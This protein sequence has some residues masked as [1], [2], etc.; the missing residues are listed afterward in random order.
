VNW[1]NPKYWSRLGRGGRPTYED[2]CNIIFSQV[3]VFTAWVVFINFIQDIIAFEYVTVWAL[4]LVLLAVTMAFYVANERGY[5]LVS[6]IA[7]GI[8]L[9]A[10]IFLLSATTWNINGVGTVYLPIM[11]TTILVMGRE[12]LWLAI[13]LSVVSFLCLLYLEVEDY[14][15]P[16]I[17]FTGDPRAD[18]LSLVLNMS[19]A[20]LVLIFAVYSLIRIN[21]ESETELLRQQEVL[22]KV[23]HELDQFVYSVSHDLR[24]P[25]ASVRGLIGIARHDIRDAQSVEYLGRMES[26][27]LRMDSFINDIVNYSRNA[28]LKF[29]PQTFNLYNLVQEVI[30]GLRYLEGAGSIRIEFDLPPLTSVLSDRNRL[31]V[32]LN[33]L[34]AN[35]IKYRRPKTECWIRISARLEAGV[36]WLQVTDNGIGIASEHL[37]RVV[38]MFYRATEVSQGSGLGL[39]IVKEIVGKMKGT[40]KIE[41]TPGE[42][43]IVTVRLPLTTATR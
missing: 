13:S 18:M 33:N 16:W 36:L 31:A 4:D 7:Y 38:E 34:L 37:D 9:N 40:L 3:L 27:V 32:I 6:K 14:R 43:T 2:R 35:S 21:Q 29:V 25:L 28:R 15:L 24:A 8:T 17:P 12:R 1:V 19:S 41:S 30:E 11:A 42:G 39:Y 20:Y 10:I 26:M 22:T 5:H 23:N